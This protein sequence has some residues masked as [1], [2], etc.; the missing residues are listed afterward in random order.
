MTDF[1]DQSINSSWSVYAAPLITILQIAEQLGLNQNSLLVEVGLDA[2]ELSIPDRRFPVM[3]YYRLYEAVAKESNDPDIALSVGRI[4]YLKGLNFQ[5]YMST[6]CKS[7]RDYLNLMPST[8]KLRGDLGEIRAH[9]EGEL[10][11]LCWEPLLLGT[12][13]KRFLTDEMLSV[14]VMIINSICIIIKC[15]SWT[16]KSS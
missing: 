7:F 16:S 6:V 3:I 5:L 12:Q 9:R 1:P 8:L 2:K 13:R 11:E 15:S 4:N 10:V 14:S